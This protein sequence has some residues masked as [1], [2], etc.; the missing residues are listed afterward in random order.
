MTRSAYI[1]EFSP[2]PTRGI[3]KLELPSGDGRRQVYAAHVPGLEVGELSKLTL[4]PGGKVT[5]EM[6]VD[7]RCSADAG[8]YA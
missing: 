1:K 5:G 3:V 2:Q 8:K 7:Q 4:N 6:T